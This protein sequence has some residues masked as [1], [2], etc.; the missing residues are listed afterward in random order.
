MHR[1]PI[2]TYHL[3]I[4]LMQHIIY[5]ECLL[6]IESS[7][8]S[9]TVQ[10]WRG[11]HQQ[12]LGPLSCPL[13]LCENSFENISQFYQNISGNNKHPCKRVGNKLRP[14]YVYNDTN[15]IR[16][17]KSKRYPHNHTYIYIST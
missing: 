16:V 10:V 14:D 13:L 3:I 4:Y 11:S 1:I 12:V 7:R 5:K 9:I 15:I 6:Y 8:W 17:K 2:T